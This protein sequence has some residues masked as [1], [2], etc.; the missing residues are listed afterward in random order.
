M[1]SQIAIEFNTNWKASI[2]KINDDLN[3]V[4]PNFKLGARVL[5][6]T[7]TALVL[8]Y[9]RYVS[10]KNRFLAVWDIALKGQKTKVAPVGIQTLLVEI[11]K[12]RSTFS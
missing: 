5:H 3:K 12:F 10:T 4:F 8:F 7:L 6:A 2:E 11:K 1:L 9:K